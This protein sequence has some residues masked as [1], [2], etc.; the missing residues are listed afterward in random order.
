ME[1]K[2]GLDKQHTGS[3]EAQPIDA[4]GATAICLPDRSE[5]LSLAPK[6]EAALAYKTRT[7]SLYFATLLGIAILG[8]D[9]YLTHTTGHGYKSP[10]WAVAIITATYLGASGNQLAGLLKI[11]RRK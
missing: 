1:K 11:F 6:E 9:M 10:D 2:D 4:P 7:A 8:F 3:I 5:E